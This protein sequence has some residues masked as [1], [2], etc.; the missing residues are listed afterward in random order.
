MDIQ[1]ILKKE[2]E[3]LVSLSSLWDELGLD[4]ATRRAHVEELYR[5]VEEIFDDKIKQERNVRDQC[6]LN[7]ERCRTKISQI[8]KQLGQDENQY[9]SLNQPLLQELGRLNEMLEGLEGIKEQRVVTLDDLLNQLKRIYADL[10]M[11]FDAKVLHYG[12]DLST[13]KVEEYKQLIFKAEE[14]RKLRLSFI[15]ALVKSIN[16]LFDELCIEP[17]AS[18]EKQVATYTEGSL[19]ASA[20]ILQQLEE[21]EKELVAEK[22]KRDALIKDLAHKISLLWERLKIP[23]PE[24]DAFLR[25]Q[26]GP[27]NVIIEACKA[28][29]ARLEALKKTSMRELIQSVRVQ[30]AAVWD[31]LQV[32]E[33]A[34]RQF[35]VYYSDEITD[36]VLSWHEEMLSKWEDKL[37]EAKPILKLYDERRSLRTQKIQLEQSSADPKR[38]LDTKK[39]ATF[40]LQEEKLRKRIEKDLPIIEDRLRSTILAWETKQ[41]VPF[42]LNDQR[43]V[44]L[45]DEEQADELRTKLEAKAKKEK[46]R[47]ERLGIVSSQDKE[48]AHNGSLGSSLRPKTPMSTHKTLP[49]TTAPGSVTK[50]A[51][52]AV[53]ATSRTATATN[54]LGSTKKRLHSAT[55]TGNKTPKGSPLKKM[56][57]DPITPT[58]LF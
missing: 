57:L 1:R 3:S 37:E 46:E 4:A 14:E 51:T 6:V 43:L 40:L 42:T 55:T 29:L 5:K 10:E 16:E 26:A 35:T 17:V 9:S 24:R 56:R 36:D 53:S 11:A 32:T 41:G 38:L 34:R 49:R 45:L 48:N 52:K 27:S 21:K 8:S 18:L 25:R 19:G 2:E 39:S 7:I 50:S 54:V 33:E 47:Q 30:I 22:R 15:K 23:I 44:D 28:E 20:K 12:E 31:E 58:K 13:S